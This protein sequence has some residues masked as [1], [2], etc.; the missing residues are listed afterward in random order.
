MPPISLAIPVSNRAPPTMNIATKRITLLSMKPEKAV[1]M[2][3]TPVTT[4]PMQTIIAVRPS[5]IFSVT[6]MTIANA[7]KHRVITA[8]L[9]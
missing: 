5:G 3:R 8:G 9:M 6:N 4:R 7:R 1:F 2:S